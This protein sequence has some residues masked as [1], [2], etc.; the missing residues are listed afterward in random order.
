[1]IFSVLLSFGLGILIYGVLI[2]IN[3]SN[4]IYFWI[5]L[6]IPA[7]T[8]LLFYT[9]PS[10]EAN[11]NDKAIMY[12][13]P[14]ATIHMSAIATSDIEPTKIF[15]IIA[16]TE[17]YKHVGREMRKI[18][19]QVEIYGYDLVTSL[20]NVASQISNKK[21]AELLGGLAINI[22]TGGELKTYLQK[23]AE[24]YLVDYRLERKKYI[25]IAGTF[26]DIYIAILIAT[27]LILVLMFVLMNV[28]GLG[29][30]GIS[31]Q[32]LMFF[33]IAIVIVLNIIFLLVLNIKQPKV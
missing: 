7:I 14:F 22:S 19:S 16:A 13:L 18:I 2:L 33:A 4:W 27:P 17:D 5:V 23:K 32:V 15:K 28:S 6:L 20:K 9:Y 1:M 21:M 29:F 12:E 30:E 25:D 8:F 3:L 24:N 31:L 10:G 11:S 26:M